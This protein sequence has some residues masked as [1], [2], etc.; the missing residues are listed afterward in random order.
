MDCLSWN[1]RG[2]ANRVTRLHLKDLLRFHKPSVFVL[3]ETKVSG[4]NAQKIADSFKGWNCV[5]S[6]AQGRSGG[7]WV[8]WRSSEVQIRVIQVHHQFVHCWIT[9]NGKFLCLSS[10]IYASPC[11][12]D[13]NTLWD[14]LNLLSNNINVP[15]FLIGDFNDIGSLD[16]QRG[17]S[18]R[19]NK[20]SINHKAQMDDCGL[21]DI[22]F[23]GVRFTWRRRFLSVRLDKAYGNVHSRT[24]FPE[25]SVINLPYRHSDHASILFKMNSLVGQKALRPFRYLMAWEDHSDFK[26]VVRHAWANLTSPVLAATVFKSNVT[27]WNREVFGNIFSRKHMIL[28]RLAGVQRA[29]SE[30]CND[31]LILLERSLQNELIDVLRHEE[32]L[33]FQKSRKQWLTK[34]DRNTKYFHLS[35]IIRRKQN[36]IEVI[37]LNNGNW[38]YDLNDIRSHAFNFYKNLFL[39]DQPRSFVSCNTTISFPHL[40]DCESNDIFRP[41]SVEDIRQALF[42]MSPNKAPGIDGLPAAFYQRHW[43]IVKD[44]LCSFVLNCFSG[45]EDIASVNQTFLVLIPKIAN[46]VSFLQFR[47]ISLCNVMYKLITKII[48]NRLQLLLP[49]II[50]PTQCSFVPG[51]DESNKV[52]KVLWKLKIPQCLKTFAWLAVHGRLLTNLERQRRHLIDSGYCARCNQADESVCHVIRDCPLSANLWRDL[53][54]QDCCHKLFNLNSVNWFAGSLCKSDDFFQVDNWRLKFV[55]TASIIWE[56][57]NKAIFQNDFV[58]PRDKCDNIRRRWDE[59]ERGWSE[60]LN[61]RSNVEK[62]EVWIGWKEPKTGW[63]KLNSDGSRNVETNSIAAGGVI[64]DGEG[65]WCSGFVH[66]IGKGSSFEAKLWGVLSGLKLA[67]DLRINKLMVEA[68]CMEVVNMINNECPMHHPSRILIRNIQRLLSKFEAVQIIHI[69]REGNRVADRLARKA[70]DGPLGLN[71]LPEAPVEVI[72]LL[73]EDNLRVCFPR[74][75]AT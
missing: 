34:G 27:K 33:W 64:R 7:I 73:H 9:Q 42:D 28:K 35:T 13:R 36:K 65:K 43:G 18:Q 5:R 31:Y 52:F 21:I 24:F 54:P 51:E 37:Q 2:A 16:D 53:L 49:K 48:A 19:Y 67:I 61:A 57:R 29:I 45:I 40:S 3:L 1:V 58:L 10:F 15:W 41:V 55:V 39:E 75:I 8:F 60:D 59:I 46:P 12:S 30:G 71:N 4:P 62:L 25:A 72:S 44:S 20:R 23:S 50:A 22:G 32:L 68:D 14:N 69:H 6:E 63:W 66:N 17:G 26:N 47:S 70:H 74:F 56:W 38:I 11:L